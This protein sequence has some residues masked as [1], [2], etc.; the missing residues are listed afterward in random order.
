MKSRL[1]EILKSI[2]TSQIKKFIKKTFMKCNHNSHNYNNNHYNEDPL[3]SLEDNNRSNL[4][5]NYYRY[6]WNSNFSSPI[7]RDLRNG[8]NVIDLGLV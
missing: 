7:E 8:A 1:E 2:E 3:S 4:L 6:I 5:H